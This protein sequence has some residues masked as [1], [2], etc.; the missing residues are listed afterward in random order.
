MGPGG[1]SCSL[2]VH[3]MHKTSLW[4]P[5]GAVAPFWGTV[6]GPFGSLMANDVKTSCLTRCCLLF[7]GILMF[8]LSG[9]LHR[10][11]LLRPIWNGWY[12]RSRPRFVL[13][14]SISN[15]W[16]LRALHCFPTLQLC[17]KDLLIEGAGSEAGGHG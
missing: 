17:G 8:L 9:S 15:R 2:W 13:K 11:F 4:V 14:G 10:F 5:R 3:G 1:H 7:S 12:L 6:S 16:S